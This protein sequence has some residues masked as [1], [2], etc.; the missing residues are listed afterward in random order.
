MVE[1][2]IADYEDRVRAIFTE[3]AKTDHAME[4]NVCRG[5]DLD[6]W[7]PLLAWFRECGGSLVTVGADAHRPEDVAKGIPAVLDMLKAA[8]FRHVTTYER[9]KPVLH[10]L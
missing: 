2:S 5:N 7:P 10:K 1:L 6:S 9:R 3:V 4:V 8:G